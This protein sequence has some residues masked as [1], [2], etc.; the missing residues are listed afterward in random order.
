MNLSPINNKKMNLKEN[1]DVL[2]AI[3][4]IGIVLMIIIPLP[5]GVLDVLL[6]L[7]ITL[8]VVIMLITMFT[9]NV[10]QLSVF[11]TLLLVTTLF[12]LALNI[13]STRLILTEADAGSI[14]TA[15]GDFVVGGN[16]A[17]GI[18]I[19][20]II[21]IVNFL[22]ITNG[23]GRVAEVSA[24]FTLDAMPGKQMSIDADLNSGLIDEATAKSR[25]QDLQSEADFYGAMDGASKFVKGDAIAG[26]IITLINIVG[27]IIIGVMM[28]GMSAGDAASKYIILTVGDGL[29]GQIPAL[30][31]STSSGILVT[32]SGSRDNFG[33][34]FANQ[35]TAF[36]VVTGIAAILMFSIG[37]IPGMPKLPFFLAAAAM[38][39]LTYLL[40]KEENKKQ[41]L[42]IAMEEDEIV[43]ME[44]KEP[45][46]V[47]NLISVE[48]MEV[49][50]GYGLIPLADE[51]TGGDLLQRIASVRRQCAIE[52]GIVVQPI[53][54]RDNLQLRTNE[55]VIKIRGTVIASSEL[56][57]NML[58]C[59]D[60]T[61]DNSDIPGIK[62]IEPTF[63]LPAVW[64]NKDQREEAEIKGLTVV[65]PTTVMVTHLTETI[66][67][68]S[69]EL[70]G[71][72]EVKLIVDN[73]REKYSA[74][75]D[76]LIPDLLTIGELQKVL[77]NLLREK[78]PIK[79][80]VTIMESLADNSR[81]TKDIELLTEYVRFS[82]ARTI[83][84]QIIN[85]DRAVTVVT[86]HPQLEELVASNIQKSIQGTFPTIDPD[87]TTRIFNNIRDT[88]ESVYFYNNQPVILV[89]PN[90]RCV[91]RKLIEMAF[92][93]LMVISLNEIPNDVEIRTEGVV[94]L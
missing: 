86:L 43:E 31:I 17:V 4:V 20:I 83:C 33:K 11:P 21:V 16:Y 65:D 76:E 89:S 46:N 19:F 71:R 78:V 80:M 13:S 49:E 8:S 26:I 68:H 48:P 18:I 40:Y 52:M 10:L 7:N 25:R 53:R 79:D 28:K 91:F 67:A 75:V 42:A 2:V 73:T 62:T 39:V 51:T 88:I 84:N 50:I 30:L 27:G 82:L 34:T 35:L 61:G 3:G 57:P 15:F 37:I 81:N 6:A 23:A 38:G 69:Y 87:T 70:L 85:E 77:Q 58:L 45:E 47:M 59:M 72:Q 56:M 54:I 66:K 32:R 12:R 44:R 63:G 92:P 29:V 24:R 74:V 22:V 93:H 1:L 94:T 36:P 55:Y 14:I 64:V 60:P 9:T 5:K 90:I 41:E